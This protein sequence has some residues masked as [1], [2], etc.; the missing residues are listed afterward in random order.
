MDDGLVLCKLKICLLV[1]LVLILVVMD[2][3]LVLV[4]K[5]LIYVNPN[6]S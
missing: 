6:K 1:L 3:G 5:E 2:D 4:M